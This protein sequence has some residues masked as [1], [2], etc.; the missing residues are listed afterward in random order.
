[1]RQ[2]ALFTL[3]S[4]LNTT[5]YPPSLLYLLM[6]LGPAMLLLRAVEGWMPAWL[7]PAAVIGKAPLTYYLAHFF[8]IHMLATVVCYARYGSAHWMYESPDLAHYPF[9]PPP[10]WGFSLLTVYAV[11]TFVVVCMYPL[12]RGVAGVKQRRPDGWLSYL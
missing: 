12:C 6:T 9:S 8:F 2:S 4:F 3:L 1:M 7:R 11:W 5:K 10:G